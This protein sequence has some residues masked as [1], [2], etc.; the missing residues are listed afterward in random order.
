MADDI[1]DEVLEEKVT[2][3]MDKLDEVFQ[4]GYSRMAIAIAC[5]RSIAAMLGPV[6][7]ENRPAMLA[8]IPLEIERVLYI[9]DAKMEELLQESK[10]ARHH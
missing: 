10:D 5:A 3:L 4:G 2:E 8:A 7:P 9:I 6:K 1:N